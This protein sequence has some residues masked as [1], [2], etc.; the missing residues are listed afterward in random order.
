VKENNKNDPA[1]AWG[2]ENEGPILDTNYCAEVKMKRPIH[3]SLL[4]LIIAT[5]LLGTA[6]GAFLSLA[7]NYRALPWHPP[8]S[9]S[10]T[11]FYEASLSLLVCTGIGAAS[12]HLW[13]GIAIGLVLGFG[14]ALW[15]WLQVAMSV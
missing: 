5:S 9:L 11:G 4:Q 3:I 13:I 8:K 15:G 10:E 2:I 7:L 6:L 1:A 14:F 12:R